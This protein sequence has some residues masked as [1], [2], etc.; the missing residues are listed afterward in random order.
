ML[1][2]LGFGFDFNNH[3]LTCLK[4][5]LQDVCQNMFLF[6]L[7]KVKVFIA[8]IKEMHISYKRVVA[9]ITKQLHYRHKDKELA[10]FKRASGESIGDK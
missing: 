1:P 2:G 9:K 6:F 8:G 7:M 3:K 10:K 4:L 5:K